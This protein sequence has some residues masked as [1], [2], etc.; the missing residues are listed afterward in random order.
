[1]RNRV[2]LVVKV[3]RFVV[4][5]LK[6]DATE[7][8]LNDNQPMRQDAK[9]FT[10]VRRVSCDQ[11]FGLIPKSCIHAAAQLVRCQ[12]VLQLAHTLA[13]IDSM[14]ARALHAPAAAAACS[15][16]AL[17]TIAV[18]VVLRTRLRARRTAGVHWHAH[19]RRAARWSRKVPGDA[20]YGE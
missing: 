4:S 20:E 2:S 9:N 19:V 1:M 17:A 15:S 8:D 18:I 5:M 12:Q 13:V 3:R 14:Q 6:M 16:D 7:K 11:R 10:S